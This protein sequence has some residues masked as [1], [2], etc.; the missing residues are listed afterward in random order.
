MKLRIINI[1]SLKDDANEEEFVKLLATE[2][3]PLWRKIPGCLKVE[4]LKNRWMH[5][6]GP[7]ASKNVYATTELWDSEE[8]MSNLMQIAAEGPQSEDV[9]RGKEILSRWHQ[10]AD[11]INLHTSVIHEE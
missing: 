1:F 9:K 2:Y 8:S 5:K 3:A 7:L 6:S 10:Y 4:I 11:H